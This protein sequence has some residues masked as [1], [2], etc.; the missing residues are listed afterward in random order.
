M[1]TGDLDEGVLVGRVHCPLVS[2]FWLSVVV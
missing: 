2:W 1:V